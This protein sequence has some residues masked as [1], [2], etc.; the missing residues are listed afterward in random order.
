MCNI[1]NNIFLFFFLLG[2]GLAFIAYPEALSNLPLPQFWSVIFFFML[3][4]LGLD[5]EVN[6]KSKIILKYT[7]ICLKIHR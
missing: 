2:Y 6:C 1:L 5:S 7:V 3:F 4:T